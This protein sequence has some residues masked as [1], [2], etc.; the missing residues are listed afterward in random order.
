MT[1]TEKARRIGEKVRDEFGLHKFGVSPRLLM[2][3]IEEELN[4]IDAEERTASRPWPQQ[5]PGMDY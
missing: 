3:V 5:E 4:S 2:D 1:N